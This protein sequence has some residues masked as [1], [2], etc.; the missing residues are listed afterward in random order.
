M[1]GP[2]GARTPVLVGV[3]TATGSGADEATDLMAAAVLAAAADAGVPGLASRADRIAVPQGTWSYPDPARLVAAAVGAR[4]ARTHLVEV[5]VPQQTLVSAALAAVAAG[6]SDVAV[7]VGGEAKARADAARRAGASAGETDQPGA[8]PDELHRR[9]GPVVDPVEVA[10]GLWEPVVQYAMIDSA[11]RAAEGASISAHRTEIDSLWSRF[12][13]VAVSNPAAAFARPMSASEIGMPAPGNRLLAFPYNA[14]HATRWGVDQAAALLV[15]SAEA[16]ERAGV[17]RDRW[18]FPLVALESS[19]AVPLVRRA[20][21]WRWPAMELLGRA[22]AAHVGRRLADVEVTEVYS[23]FPAAVRVQQRELELDPGGTPTVTG[24]MTFAGGPFNNFT[25]QAL[26]AVVPRLRA[27]PGALGLVTT[28]SGLL[29]KP[30]IGVW[31]GTP[32]VRPALVAD[33]ADPAAATTGVRPA[34]DTLDAY[35]G[36]GKVAMYTVTPVDGV[37]ARTVVVADTP[38]GV[39]AV[40][41]CDDPAVAQQAMSE[42]LVGADAYLERGRFVPV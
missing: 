42:E 26:A 13:R 32:P 30:G 20:Q 24:G 37:P 41:T 5:G 36:P 33:L 18:V 6:R 38:D 8:V 15:C 4:G 35:A 14:W 29:T 7:I 28:V 21:P 3:G 9:P 12:N 27:E 22:A 2:V 17:P 40:A 25:Y 1:T 31:G 34:Y 11:L 39:R 16:A 19:H 23:C 10:T